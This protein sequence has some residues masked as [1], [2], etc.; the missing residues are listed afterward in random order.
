MMNIVMR[1]FAAE[2]NQGHSQPAVL[3][4]LLGWDGFAPV[5][6]DS[7]PQFLSAG[8]AGGDGLEFGTHTVGRKEEQ[9]MDERRDQREDSML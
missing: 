8:Q 3:L 6:L 1:D 5:H 2:L 7:L 4:M 9:S